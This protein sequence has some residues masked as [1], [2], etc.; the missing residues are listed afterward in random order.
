MPTLTAVPQSSPAVPRMPANCQAH[1]PNDSDPFNV[2]VFVSSNSGG[3]IS[4]IPAGGQEAVTLYCA[5]GAVL[6]VMV[7]TVRATGTTAT[8]IR[9]FW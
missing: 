3:D 8:G 1:T 9:V 2:P 6:P 7:T 4:V 5:P